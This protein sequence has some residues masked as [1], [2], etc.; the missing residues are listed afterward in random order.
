MEDIIPYL[1][2]FILSG[3]PV[4]YIFSMA[5]IHWS[6]FDYDFKKNYFLSLSFLGIALITSLTLYCYFAFFK[7]EGLFSLMLSPCLCT[8]TCFILLVYNKEDL[9]KNVNNQK[10]VAILRE[11]FLEKVDRK[12][13]KE[14]K[15]Y[16]DAIIRG[17]AH[18]DVEKLFP[19]IAIQKYYNMGGS[20][21]SPH[22]RPY[23]FRHPY[24]VE[25]KRKVDEIPLEEIVKRIDTFKNNGQ[26]QSP[27]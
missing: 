1:L 2:F 6:L 25:F 8:G 4:L 26:Y 19:F 14:C 18:F 10:K 23:I 9:K 15:E 12:R 21:M 13:W 3:V 5:A 11:E 27:H 24:Y 16:F 17:E 22:M 7:N 20:T